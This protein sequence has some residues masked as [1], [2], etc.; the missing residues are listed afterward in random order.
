MRENKKK[1][2]GGFFSRHTA[3]EKKKNQYA[4][5]EYD[6]YEPEQEDVE[7]LYNDDDY[8]D[9][10]PNLA[11][12]QDEP[13]EID[14]QPDDDY[15][16]DGEEDYP[17]PDE[18]GDTAAHDARRDSR[19]KAKIAALVV[20]CILIVLAAGVTVGGYMVTNS[21]TNFP[22]LRV[23][24]SRSVGWMPPPQKPPLKTAAGMKRRVSL[25]R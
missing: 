7:P 24:G 5:D 9:E 10:Q 21:T 23:G 22:N 19:R 6:P 14:E 3:P 13:D 12:E 16:D 1:K 11:Y 2:T 15:Y 25:S 17:E 18:D 20:A 4:E 8:A